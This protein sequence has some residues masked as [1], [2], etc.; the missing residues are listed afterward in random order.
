VKRFLPLLFLLVVLFFAHV[1]V[2]RHAVTER[3]QLSVDVQTP[4]ALPGPILRVTALDYKGVLADFLFLKSLVFIGATDERDYKPRVSAD[5][6]HWLLGELSASVDLDPMFIDP[7]YFANANLVWDG[8]LVRETNAL[9]DKGRVARDWD[10]LLPFYMGFNEFY[11]LDD[12]ELAIK[13]LKEAASR[14][15]SPPLLPLLI[16]RLSYNQSRTE[17][18]I[19]Y[20]QHVLA[21]SKDENTI[22]EFK[23]RLDALLAIRQLEIAADKYVGMF[24]KNPSAIDDL[25]SSGVVKVIPVDPFGGKFYI[26]K[27]GNIKTT[28]ELRN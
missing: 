20:V 17:S 24:H 21:Q 15:D 23:K 14:K 13:Y 22:K 4:V 16:V 28:S 6:W 10:W 18:A 3:K 2:T 5:E 27:K 25:V 1:Q 12:N 26:D 19:L 7:Y 9:L 11:F 8:H